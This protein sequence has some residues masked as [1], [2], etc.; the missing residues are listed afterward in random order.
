MVASDCLK[1]MELNGLTPKP[2]KATNHKTFIS[3]CKT[4]TEIRLSNNGE[5]MCDATDGTCNLHPPNMYMYGIE[6]NVLERNVM[7][8]HVPIYPLVNV[9]ITMEN[10]HL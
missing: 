4:C 2:E 3:S 10:H 5:F 8:C 7:S 1:T 9:Y 6:W